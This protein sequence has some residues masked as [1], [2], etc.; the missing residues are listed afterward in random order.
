MD[1]LW[2]VRRRLDFIDRL[3]DQT[4]ATFQETIRKINA[5]EPPFEYVGD[6]D[7]FGGDP[8]YLEEHQQAAE[9]VEVIGHWCL[10]MVY[11][12]LRAY[13]EEYL[14]EMARDYRQTFGDLPVR[15]AAKKA[16]SWFERYRLLFLD[17]MGIDW[18]KGPAKLEDLE[19]LNLARDDIT[20]NVDVMSIYAYQTER[21][22]AQYP[23]GPFVDELWTRLN[24]GGRIRVGRDELSRALGM[25]GDFCMWLEDIRNRYPAFVR[26]LMAAEEEG[27]NSKTTQ[28]P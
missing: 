11:A 18:Q 17:D 1:L 12:S 19:H 16:K 24:L 8:P 15:L 7:N 26:S 25:V 22:A 9:S 4:T 5:G 20:H 13:L 23:K 10:C 3:Y 21:H 28:H 14:A 27:L 6:P 2:F